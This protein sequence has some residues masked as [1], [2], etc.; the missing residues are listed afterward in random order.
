MRLIVRWRGA[1]AFELKHG[2]EKVSSENVPTASFFQLLFLLNNSSNLDMNLEE[3]SETSPTCVSQSWSRGRYYRWKS[4]GYFFSFVELSA[5]VFAAGRT[6]IPCCE[7]DIE[8][9]KWLLHTRPFNSSRDLICAWEQIGMRQSLRVFRSGFDCTS[10]NLSYRRIG[11]QW[12]IS[13]SS[14]AVWLR[15]ASFLQPSRS[16]TPKFAIEFVKHQWNQCLTGYM[17]MH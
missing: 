5:A 4:R 17:C 13:I 11:C 1:I 12:Q 9:R 16:A 6:F 3:L 10:W 2:M 15:S 8:S 7:G 14:L